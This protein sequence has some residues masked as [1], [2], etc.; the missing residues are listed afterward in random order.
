MDDFKRGMKLIRDKERI[1]AENL[2]K[3]LLLMKPRS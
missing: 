3:N 1:N 2:L